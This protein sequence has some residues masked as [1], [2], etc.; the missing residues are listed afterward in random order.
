MAVQVAALVVQLFVAVSGVELVLLLD[1]HW[2][3]L[4]GTD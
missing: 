2:F 3:R 1:D 4:P